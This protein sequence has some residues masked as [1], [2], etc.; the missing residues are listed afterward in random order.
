MDQYLSVFFERL[1]H[2]PHWGQ[3]QDSEEIL[4][5]SLQISKIMHVIYKLTYLIT[6]KWD[7][8]IVYRRYGL[9]ELLNM[10]KKGLPV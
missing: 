6:G 4:P 3:Q 7:S 2:P 9:L 8:Q 10:L 1:G 5:H